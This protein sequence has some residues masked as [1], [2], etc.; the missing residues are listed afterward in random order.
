MINWT[1]LRP[2][3]SD[4]K[5]FC[6]Y[7]FL[8]RKIKLMN[9]VAIYYTTFLIGF[10]KC[11]NKPCKQ[12]NLMITFLVIAGLVFLIWGVLICAA[13]CGCPVTTKTIFLL[14]TGIGLSCFASILLWIVGELDVPIYNDLLL[15]GFRL[16]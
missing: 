12:I 13:P 16:N 8:I 3:K 11:D 5:P 2:N 6:I 4:V 1:I 9:V 7:L 14:K 10:K 15:T